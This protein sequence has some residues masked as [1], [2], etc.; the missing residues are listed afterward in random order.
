MKLSRD[1]TGLLAHDREL[2]FEALE[3]IID[4]IGR[5]EKSTHQN[6]WADV[7]LKLLPEADAIIEIDDLGC[8]PG[9]TLGIGGECRRSL[10]QRSKGG[11]DRSSVNE[12]TA[13]ERHGESSSV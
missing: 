10:R 2:P 9:R 11:S 5:N 1:Q 13:R 4:L 6:D 8:S 12:I 3:K 7:V